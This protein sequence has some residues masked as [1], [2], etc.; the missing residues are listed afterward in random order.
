MTRAAAFLLSLLI[1]FSTQLVDSTEVQVPTRAEVEAMMGLPSDGDRV[2]G[3]MDTIGFVV[4]ESPAEDVV[5]TAVR[6][7]HKSLAA[8]DQQHGMTDELAGAIAM[9]MQENGW[10]LG[11]DI[12]VVVS[13]DA[14]HYGP[15]FDHT[16]FGTGAEAYE[17]ATAR[18]RSLALD[19]LVGNLDPSK[20]RKF[21]STLVDPDTLEYRLPWCGRFSIPFGLEL[22]R[23][24]SL[25]TAGKVPSGAL[26]RYGTSLSEP[27]LPV[28]SA[29]RS[30][31]LGY[32]APS[33]FHHWVGYAA[34]GYRL[35]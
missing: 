28:S 11:T 30:S 12:A 35:E 14:V 21:S 2:R 10:Q 5:A 24:L 9:I 27:E 1:I 26:L 4:E 23:K 3:Q 18:E 25:S 7:E 20:L 15:D 22:L 19:H 17:K 34:V 32:T 33:N 16:P 31:G 6:L 13:S 8:Q 29:T